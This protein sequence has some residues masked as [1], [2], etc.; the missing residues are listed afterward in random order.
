MLKIIKVNDRLAVGPQPDLS[1][2][3][4]L[5]SLGFGSV[6]N[7]RPDGEEPSQ[8]T[9]ADASLKA[10][11]AGLR[12]ARQPIVLNAIS[13]GDIRQ[14]QKEIAQLDGPVFAH[15]KSGTRS[16]TLWTLG[17]V[18]DGRMQA[19]EILPFGERHGVELKVAAKWAADHAAASGNAK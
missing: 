3:H 8:P 2:F 15:C 19:S 17:E 5:K 9:A 18:L 11:E 10:E 16:L 7:N 14:F 1:D 4:E 12:Y 13:E 6:V